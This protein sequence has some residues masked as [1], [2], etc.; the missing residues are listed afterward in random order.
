M[1][2]RFQCCV[3]DFKA[4]ATC[5]GADYKQTANS[6]AGNQPPRSTEACNNERLTS[7]SWL[8]VEQSSSHDSSCGRS[9]SRQDAVRPKGDGRWCW[10]ERDGDSGE[11]S[12]LHVPVLVSSAGV[13]VRGVLSCL[14]SSPVLGPR[15]HA[16]GE[17]CGADDSE[18]AA[19][20]GLKK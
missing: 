2:P 4:A 11:P 17:G 7:S 1:K 19:A 15:C 6:Q 3:G 8:R 16:E 5:P 10:N 18:V 14:F 9:E 13:A 20:A 12:G